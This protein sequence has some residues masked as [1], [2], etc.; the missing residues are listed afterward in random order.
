MLN[1]DTHP[2]LIWLWKWA[3]L[4]EHYHVSFIALVERYEDT[5]PIDP[6][7]ALTLLESIFQWTVVSRQIHGWYVAER[8]ALGFPV[9]YTP[10]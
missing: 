7:A 9:P 3:Q 6:R 2:C 4:T 5:K 1:H 10:L 8:A